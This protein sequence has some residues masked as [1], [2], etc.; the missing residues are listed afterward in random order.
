[1]YDAFLTA[2]RRKI[3]KKN[4]SQREVGKLIGTSDVTV[5][6]TLNRKTIL[7]APY[8]LRM[9]KQLNI[10]LDACI[11]LGR[12]RPLTVRSGCV[13]AIRVLDEI[14]EEGKMP[15]SQYEKLFDAIAA[16]GGGEEKLHDNRTKR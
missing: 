13:N 2:A 11:G 15:Y 3:A 10:S 7:R 14:F 12:A 16:I 4:L 8:M 1:M 6:L 5:C 9:A